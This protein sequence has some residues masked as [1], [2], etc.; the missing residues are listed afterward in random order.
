MRS[1]ADAPTRFANVDIDVH[2]ETG[3]AEFITALGRKAIPMYREPTWASFELN[4]TFSDAQSCLDALTA[5]IEN[6]SPEARSL[7]DGFR[8]R[9]VNIGVRAGTRPHSTEFGISQT[10]M[11]AL[12]AIG[13][14]ITFT[15]YAPSAAD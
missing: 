15:V 4:D 7:W 14:E 9:T 1:E 10:T 13:C 6:L 8:R 3:V 2:G 5:A 11:A 12:A